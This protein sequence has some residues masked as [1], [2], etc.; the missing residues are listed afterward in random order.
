MM[1]SHQ[2]LIILIIFNQL[3]N[4]CKVY[5]DHPCY[6]KVDGYPLN[7]GS[8]VHENTSL[9]ACIDLCLK[10]ENICKSFTYNFDWKTCH[11]SSTIQETRTTF[12][13]FNIPNIAYYIKKEFC[14]P[15]CFFKKYEER[16]LHGFSYKTIKDTDTPDAC[17]DLCLAE[18]ETCNSVEYNIAS[19]KCYL[20]RYTKEINPYAFRENCFFTY[21]ERVCGEEPKAYACFETHNNHWLPRANSRLI[22]ENYETC[23]YECLISKKQCRSVQ[24]DKISHECYLN[25]NDSETEELIFNISFVHFQRSLDC[26]SDC[27][28]EAHNGKVLKRLNIES[29]RS[30]SNLDCIEQCFATDNCNSVQRNSDL[31]VCHLQIETKDNRPDNFESSP[32]YTYWQFNCP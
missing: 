16:Y 13:E 5:G 3:L 26:T 8:T 14:R 31:A 6:D 22:S 12:N 1:P 11:L 30:L 18:M 27:S 24:Y 21:W 2:I 25:E 15:S 4:F 29:E 17:L 20:S 7:F 10:T 32:F 9:F 23:L 28:I 19:K